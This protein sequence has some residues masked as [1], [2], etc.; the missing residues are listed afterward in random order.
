VTPWREPQPLPLG[1][2]LV[3]LVRWRLARGQAR[4]AAYRAD[5]DYRRAETPANL[6][7]LIRA[8]DHLRHLEW[9]PPR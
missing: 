2:Y 4:R 7:R 8:R 3:A 9:N 5:L 1:R 6:G